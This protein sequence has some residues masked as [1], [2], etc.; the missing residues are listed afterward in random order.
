MQRVRAIVLRKVIGDA[1]E[2][3]LTIGNPIGIAADDRTEVRRIFEVS[4]E[5]IE[6][7]HDV[8]EMAGALRCADDGDDAAVRHHANRDP[9]RTGERN[10]LD[11]APVRQLPEWR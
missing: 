4:A 9:A 11:A 5:A 6:A 8:V 7:E 1:V 3:E 10:E 2:G